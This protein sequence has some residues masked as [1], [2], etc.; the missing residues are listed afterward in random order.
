MIRKDII[1]IQ[2]KFELDLKVDRP[3]QGYD[4]TNGNM[5]LPFFENSSRNSY[6]IRMEEQLIINLSILH[7]DV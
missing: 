4:I 2:K 3:K 5:A 1:E 7:H 6:I